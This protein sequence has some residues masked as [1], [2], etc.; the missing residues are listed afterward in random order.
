MTELTT[1]GCVSEPLSGWEIGEKKIPKGM[2]ATLA[3]VFNVRKRDPAPS[4]AYSAMGI[5]VL[6][7]IKEP[8][9]S[10]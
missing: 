3:S 4:V 2:K 6:R 9:T 10:V 1:E 5:I 8:G 7:D